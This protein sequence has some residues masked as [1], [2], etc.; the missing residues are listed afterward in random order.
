MLNQE[1]IELANNILTQTAFVSMIIFIFFYIKEGKDER[2]GM[3]FNVFFR[4]M[5]I[6]LSVSIIGITNVQF[7]FSVSDEWFRLLINLA[8]SAT[9][10]FGGVYLLY[11]RFK[12]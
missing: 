8:L 2:G 12:F 7:W 3:I 1:M 9:Y 10:T 11:L 4:S 6:V 5:F